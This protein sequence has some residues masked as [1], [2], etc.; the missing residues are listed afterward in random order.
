MRYVCW[1]VVQYVPRY[2][3]RNVPC[4]ANMQLSCVTALVLLLQCIGV[5]LSGLLNH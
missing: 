3:Y 2:V 5:F 4:N 1:W